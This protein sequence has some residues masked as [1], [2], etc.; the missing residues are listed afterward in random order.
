MQILIITKISGFGQLMFSR[1]RTRVLCVDRR[2]G[3]EVRDKLAPKGHIS[4]YDVTGGRQCL[5]SCLARGIA[6]TGNTGTDDAEINTF[7]RNDKVFFPPPQQAWEPRLQQPLASARGRDNARRGMT[8]AEAARWLNKAASP[9]SRSCSPSCDDP[10]YDHHSPLDDRDITHAVSAGGV[11]WPDESSDCFKGNNADDTTGQVS[12]VGHRAGDSSSYQDENKSVIHS[13]GASLAYPESRLEMYP[14]FDRGRCRPR[15]AGDNRSLM[16]STR[17]RKPYLNPAVTRHSTIDPSGCVEN[18]NSISTRERSLDCI[19]NR[20]TGGI[21][22]TSYL[23]DG[24]ATCGGD[25]GSDE[26]NGSHE[27][28]QKVQCASLRSQ[29]LFTAG[30]HA[31]SLKLT[32]PRPVYASSCGGVARHQVRPSESREREGPELWCTPVKTAGGHFL[33]SDSASVSCS[34]HDEDWVHV[35]L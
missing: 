34:L 9:R 13:N 27:R 2:H 12:S 5:A 28:A 22:C 29:R 21:V 17:S 33:K 35:S 18:K 11:A 4:D 10:G 6:S 7:S 31:C 32:T 15:T 26:E 25:S 14:I 16:A 24:V 1:I 19:N 20:E 8:A 23:D 3:G 30:T